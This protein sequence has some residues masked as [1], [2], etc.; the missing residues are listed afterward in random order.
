[1]IRP[2]KNSNSH[3]EETLS[4]CRANHSFNSRRFLSLTINKI[5]CAI[6]LNA[7]FSIQVFCQTQVLS[8][9]AYGELA[10]QYSL[11]TGLSYR[12]GQVSSTTNS[13][14]PTLYRPIDQHFD[15]HGNGSGWDFE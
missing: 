15:N 14:L 10:S 3:L 5:A 11:T 6:A 12:Y 4:L 7:V 9:A 1:M 2:S 8:K 13:G